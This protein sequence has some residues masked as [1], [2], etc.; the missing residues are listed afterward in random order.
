MDRKAFYVQFIS[1]NQ[2]VEELGQLCSRGERPT[3]IG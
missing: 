3:M 2:S 1:L